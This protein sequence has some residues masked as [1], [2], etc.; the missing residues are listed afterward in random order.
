M[1]FEKMKA[2]D[3]KPKR[4]TPS[5]E[6]RNALPWVAEL[7]WKWSAKLRGKQI[8]YWPDQKRWD[9]DGESI[10]GN[11]AAFVWAMKARA[12]EAIGD[13]FALMDA[14]QQARAVNSFIKAAAK[15]NGADSAP[16]QFREIFKLLEPDVKASIKAWFFSS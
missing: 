5:A 9:Y 12:P 15:W 3:E 14:A 4:R 13:A 11:V 2:R 7:P 16:H 8:I 6:E 10:E 1:K